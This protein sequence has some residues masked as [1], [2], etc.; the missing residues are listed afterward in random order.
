MRPSLPRRSGNRG[1]NQ[2]TA[3]SRVSGRRLMVAKAYPVSPKMQAAVDD[4]KALV[5]RAYPDATFRLARSPDEADALVLW[6]IVDV[7]DLEDVG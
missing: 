1:R 3:A 5:F 4:L 2:R 7:D 6:V